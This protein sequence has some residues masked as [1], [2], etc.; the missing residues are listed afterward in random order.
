MQTSEDN[1]DKYD[2]L[3]QK[4]NLREIPYE[5]RMAFVRER[6]Q[7]V[8]YRELLSF[9][10]QDHD[11]R[12]TAYDLL[13]YPILKF[14]S[15]LLDEGQSDLKELSLNDKAIPAFVSG[16]S[17]ANKNKAIISFLSLMNLHQHYPQLTQKIIEQQQAYIPLIELLILCLKVSADADFM[18]LYQT[19]LEILASIAG[20]EQ[21]NPETKV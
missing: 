5:V 19:G 3:L 12:P 9:M 6:V 8:A 4:V 2:K 20:K 15:Y 13:N 21:R 16:L 1:L 10:L 18:S 14:F 17:I 7:D 11:K